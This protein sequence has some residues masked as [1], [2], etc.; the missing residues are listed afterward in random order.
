MT[1]A[2]IA[3][4]ETVKALEA[5]LPG[6]VEIPGV[7]FFQLWW[8]S[9]QTTTMLTTYLLDETIAQLDRFVGAKVG[10]PLLLG[11]PLAIYAVQAASRLCKKYF[12]NKT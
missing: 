5:I 6:A 1:S 9:L 8:V 4:E 12:K 10:A 2:L 11:A 7:P 3:P